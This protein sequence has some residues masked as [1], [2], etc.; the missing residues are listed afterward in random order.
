MATDNVKRTHAARDETEMKV[1]RCGFSSHAGVV[2]IAVFAAAF[3]TH[4]TLH[5]A[6]SI[7]ALLGA[8]VC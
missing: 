6:P 5:I 8:G 1:G 3:F 2:L 4:T 7:V